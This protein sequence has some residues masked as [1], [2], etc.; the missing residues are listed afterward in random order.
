MGIS[1]L[2]K[3]VADGLR[4]VKKEKGLVAGEVFASENLAHT[5]RLHYASHLPCN[6]VEEPKTYE[7]RGLAVRILFEEGGVR[8]IGFGSEAS[9][10]TQ[11]GVK[12]ALEKARRNAVADPAFHGFPAWAK[13]RSA[14]AR[15]HDPALSRLSDKTLVD[16]GWKVVRG[17]IEGF[18]RSEALKARS[19]VMP[20]AL[21]TGSEDR[22]WSMPCRPWHGDISWPHTVLG[23]GTSA[24]VGKVRAGSIRDVRDLGLILSG[25]VSAVTERMALA[26][27]D[28]T[29]ILS[30]ETTLL[31]AYVTAMVESDNAKG[32]CTFAGPELR[33]FSGRVGFQAAENAIRCM[34]GERISSGEYRVILGPQAMADMLNNLVVPAV[35]AGTFFAGSSPF[36][37]RMDQ[38]VASE[39]LTLVDDG[40]RMGHMGTK[41]LTC[42]GISTGKT[43]LIVR[44]VLRGIL[45]SHHEGTKLLKD[46]EVKSKLGVPAETLA[47]RQLFRNGF[48]YGN[49]PGRH[50]AQAPHTAATNVLVEE[51]EK[52]LPS[53]IRD[54][55]SG[56]YIGRIWYTYPINGLQR[57][58]FTSTV[59]G[60]SFLIRNGRAEKPLRANC[61][62]IND[63]VSSVLNGIRAVG[64]PSE[65]VIIWASDEV[66]Y[67]PP[68]HIEKLHLEEIA[69]GE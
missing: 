25:D 35:T 43:E 67:S 9:D 65:P 16:L 28:A 52:D 14:K 34:G 19:G 33:G 27:T 59:V 11:R 12:R 41:A 58:D 1:I 29:G 32:T 47:S 49:S 53:L 37:G 60:D 17:G 62:R 24:I 68:V 61:V 8:K 13:K 38:R 36:Q 3:V 18:S 69:P 51:G 4:L 63:N 40:S 54:V 42:E 26:R 55:D 15:Y 48:R 66:V 2:R 5:A 21:S 57:G 6:G 56:V 22:P 30:D 39:L 31:M 20:A 44:G 10:F 45:G 23:K 7:F 64:R 50:F 46:P